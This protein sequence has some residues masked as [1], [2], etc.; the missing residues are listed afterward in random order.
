MQKCGTSSIKTLL[1]PKISSLPFV[2]EI[3][4]SQSVFKDWNNFSGPPF[5][6]KYFIS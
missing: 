1:V 2:F 3:P 4:F 6:S 5:S